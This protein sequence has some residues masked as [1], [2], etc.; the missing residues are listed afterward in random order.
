MEWQSVGN[1]YQDQINTVKYA[2]Y[3]IFNFRAGYEW[4]GI[5]IYGNIINLT[6]KI[7]TYNVSRTNT[8]NSQPAYYAAAPRTFL[9]GIQYNFSLK[10]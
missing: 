8:A 3:D 5:E 2:G 10:K 4:K 7:Y 9:I 6:D 1:Y